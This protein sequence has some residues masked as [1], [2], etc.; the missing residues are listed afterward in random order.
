MIRTRL[1]PALLVLAVTVAGC[2]STG[3]MERAQAGPFESTLSQEEFRAAPYSNMYDTVNA[4][5]SNWL[6]NSLL[7][8][9]GLLVGS[10]TELRQFRA[11]DVESVQF[12]REHQAQTMFGR[13]MN[14][15][16]VIL[17]TT[18]RGGTSAVRVVVDN[19]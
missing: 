2:T 10:T 3:G 14:F 15:R 8:V 6:Q 12:L 9:D 18:R 11:M 4:L 19:G 13:Q 5:R 7:A 1:A 16:R 17:L